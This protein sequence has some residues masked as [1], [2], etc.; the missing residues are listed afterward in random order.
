MVFYN[1]FLFQKPHNKKLNFPNYPGS[2]V[3]L[4]PD[5]K[6]LLAN[7]DLTVMLQFYF[8]SFQ[9]QLSNASNTSSKSRFAE[10]TDISPSGEVERLERLKNK[11]ALRNQTLRKDRIS[12]SY[13]TKNSIVMILTYVTCS[14]PMILC[15]LPGV[16]KT[17]S[18]S[19][20]S[21]PQMF[22]RI[23]F[24]LNA[25]AYPLWY[26][27]FSR[28][29]RKCLGRMSEHWMIRLHLKR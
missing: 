10:F 26:L 13:A 22:C 25:P 23:L 1:L 19:D 4:T 28:R 8:H 7:L 5:I 6:I 3:F 2:T 20:I 21:I 18:P 29:V 17:D 27:I 24:Y 12:L 15:T 11:C 14:L 16:L 9:S